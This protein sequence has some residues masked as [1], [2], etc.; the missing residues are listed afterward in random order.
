MP[1]SPESSHDAQADAELTMR[2]MMGFS[3]FS[4][5][6]PKNQSHTSLM[7]AQHSTTDSKEPAP[8]AP[9]SSDF[10]DSRHPQAFESQNPPGD[11]EQMSSLHNDLSPNSTPYPAQQQQQTSYAFTSPQTGISYTS[12]ELE[13][14]SRGKVNARGDKVFFKPGFVSDDPWFRLR[15]GAGNGGENLGGNRGKGPGQ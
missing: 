12:E 10:S 3:S 13:Q 6:R 5:R 7:N 15:G 8:D 1:E 14:W 9:G 4:E 2:A 11:D